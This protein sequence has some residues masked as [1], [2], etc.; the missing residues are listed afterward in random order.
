M[1]VVLDAKTLNALVARANE[2][3][4]QHCPALS[5]CKCVGNSALSDQKKHYIYTETLDRVM[6]DPFDC[7]RKL[8]ALVS[9]DLLSKTDNLLALPQISDP[10]DELH[11]QGGSP[12]FAVHQYDN[13]TLA[14]LAAFELRPYVAP[15]VFSA[16]PEKPA[17]APEP[18][19]TSPDEVLD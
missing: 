11:W 19:E 3:F 17:P 10:Q 4:L 8:A 2:G 9:R 15:K 5:R 1:H 14:L 12:I 16:I 6:A 13:S 7:G 18:L